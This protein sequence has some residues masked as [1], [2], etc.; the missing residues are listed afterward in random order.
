MSSAPAAT[1]HIAPVANLSTSEPSTL[2]PIPPPTITAPPVSVP[3]K[4]KSVSERDKRR[5]TTPAQLHWL[6][7]RIPAYLEAQGKQRYDKFWVEFFRDWFEA[8]PPRKPTESDPEYSDA[9]DEDDDDGDHEDAEENADEPSSNPKQKPVSKKKK[10]KRKTVSLGLLLDL[11]R[12]LI[13]Q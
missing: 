13:V 1:E 12:S 7:G 10:K 3:K 11:F 9:E 6:I 4:G 5:W 2:G 8:F